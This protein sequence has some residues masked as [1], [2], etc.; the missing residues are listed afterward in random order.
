[1]S[2]NVNAYSLTMRIRAPLKT[3]SVPSGFYVRGYLTGS[4]DT[5]SHRFYRYEKVSEWL[6]SD[7]P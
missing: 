3:S 7:H 6:D 5:A 4:I 1:M 2:K